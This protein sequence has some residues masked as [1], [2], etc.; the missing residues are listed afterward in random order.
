MICWHPNHGLCIVVKNYRLTILFEQANNTD[1]VLARISFVSIFVF[2]AALPFTIALTQIAL[3]VALLTW[4]ARAFLTKQMRL[5]GLGLEWAFLAYVAAEILSLIFS[6]NVS[7]SIIYL[8][9]LLL[10]P[11]VYLIALNIDS[12]SR[13][14]QLLLVFMASVT[15]Y[16]AWGIISYFVDPTVRVRHIHNSMTVGG[17][18]MIGA[19]PGFAAATTMEDKKWRWLGLF[20][21]MINLLCLILTSTRGSWLGFLAGILLILYLTNR[22]ALIAV[23][24]LIAAFY[25][26][27]PASFV[28]RVRHF[29][30]PTWGTN[31]KRL[32]WWS[33]G[34]RVIKDHPLVGI[35]D[36]GTADIYKQYSPPDVQELIGHFHSNYVHIA[37]TLGGIGLL[38]FLFM[39]IKITQALYQAYA[40]SHQT[41]ELLGTWTLA[42]LAAFLAFNLNGFFEWNF[43]DAEVITIIWFITGLALAANTLSVSRLI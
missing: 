36:V 25:L 11:I 29:F 33:V 16:S 1:T 39:L 5:H 28:H 4:M 24:V 3:G 32:L 9:R 34:V 27:Q 30:D 18:T 20:S 8:K 13:F 43:G 35:G 26:L 21:G 38:A 12:K 22:R 19:L 40:R 10:I 42:S 41:D 31:A 2:V 6:T 15:V 17:I 37:V 14:R 7:Q 23:P